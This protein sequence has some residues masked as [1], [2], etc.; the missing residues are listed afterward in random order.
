[1]LLQNLRKNLVLSQHLKLTEKEASPDIDR[2]ETNETEEIETEEEME[3][4]LFISSMAVQSLQTTDNNATIEPE[5][6]SSL[7]SHM[8]QAGEIEPKE[9]MDIENSSSIK[10]RC[11][12]T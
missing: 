11:P 7:S 2:E 6:S 4:E 8:S 5:G 9:S 3:T 12:N 1:M 10:A